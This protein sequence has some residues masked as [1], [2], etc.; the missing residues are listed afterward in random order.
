MAHQLYRVAV[1]AVASDQMVNRCTEH[2]FWKCER[3]VLVEARIYKWILCDFVEF[4]EQ[5]H[6]TK[7]RTDAT[8]KTG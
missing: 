4:L 6:V 7:K 3:Y 5:Q 2:L 1:I 8:F